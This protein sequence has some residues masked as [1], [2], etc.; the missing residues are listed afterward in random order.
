L[1]FLVGYWAPVVPQ[2]KP[3]VKDNPNKTAL[4]MRSVNLN[5]VGVWLFFD[6]SNFVWL[7]YVGRGGRGNR[8]RRD[9]V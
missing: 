1:N 2:N 9:K 8:R 6:V 5:A 7:C 3:V 4:L